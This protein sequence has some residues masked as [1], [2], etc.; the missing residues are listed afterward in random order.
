MSLSVQNGRADDLF[1]VIVQVNELIKRANAEWD[2]LHPDEDDS[3]RLLPLIRLRVRP[4][5]SPLLPLSASSLA[6][7]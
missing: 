2:E 1:G 3:E 7:R 4:P 6:P 5:L